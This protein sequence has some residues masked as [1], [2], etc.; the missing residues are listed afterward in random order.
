MTKRE[1]RYIAP[2]WIKF[3][4]YPEQSS[5]WKSGSGAEYLLK[6]NENVDNME[7][8]LELFPKSPT[9]LE[10]I[11]PDE[12]LS[13]QAKEYLCS[14]TKPLF[15]KLWRDDAKSKYSVD[16][17]ES[18]DVIFMYDF[19]LSDESRHIHIGTKTYESANDII[20]LAKKELTEKSPELWE[21]LKYTVLLNAI[22]YKIVTDINLTKEVI[23]T[24]DHIIVFK[25]DNLEW[26]VQE[27]NG[28]YVGMNLLGLAVMELRDVFKVVYENYDDIDWNLSGS[29]DSEEHCSCGHAHS[30]YKNP[31]YH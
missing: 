5:F 8:Y 11:M 20:E 28:R 21:E 19:L 17:N 12:S 18:K 2:P 10:E 27:E 3:P 9:F 6:F 13:N 1:G 7:E 30:N 24:K 16:V 25:S 15:L 29:P 22:F 4:T 23:K 14:S 26:G 31:Y